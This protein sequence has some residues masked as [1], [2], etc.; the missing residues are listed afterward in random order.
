MGGMPVAVSLPLPAA[1]RGARGRPASSGRAAYSGPAVCSRG[2]KRG[3]G[4]ARARGAAAAAASGGGEEAGAVVGGGGLAGLAAALELR[5]RGVPCT[6]VEK[7]ERAGGRVQTDEVDGF[8]LDR[9]F[10]I[11][12]TGYPEAQRVLDYDALDLRPFFA[13]ASI[14]LGPGE[15]FP[16]VADPLR[17]PVAAIQSAFGPI[18][19]PLDKVLVGA[20]RFASP[21][22]GDA[23]SLLGSGK[24]EETTAAEALR[25]LGLSES[26]V[27]PFFRPF[28]AGI[29]FNPTLGVSSRLTKFVLKVLA[30]GPQ[31]L[32]AKG[33]GAVSAQLAARAERGGARL[34]LGRGVQ[35]VEWEGAAPRVVLD[36]GAALEAPLGVVLATEGPEAFRLAGDF[37]EGAPSKAEEP[38]G[39]VCVYFRATEPPS[40]DKILFLDGRGEELVN[41][42]CVPS[43]VCPDYAPKGQ[44]LIST[45]IVGS[46][47][48]LDGLCADDAE[49]AAEVK[50]CLGGWFGEAAVAPW[51]LLK[52]Y[53]IPYG[54]PNQNPPTDFDR[55]VRLRS[56]DRCLYVCGDHR[57]S[58][59]LDGALLSG[60]RAAEALCADSGMAGAGGS[61]P[62]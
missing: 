41:N 30:D 1:G 20:L 54:Q 50:R 21:F 2:G 18:G 36:D 31:C 29:F 7:Q 39:T 59:T 23:Y 32:P 4:G 10:Q 16:R 25:G 5:R 40:R 60:R 48:Y 26:I 17:H 51:E 11:F 56:A 28:L 33:M 43:N 12:L 8:L 52:V 46:K 24:E 61:A 62:L 13:G 45:S 57:T 3:A 55:S 27:R 35:A 42:C 44:A 19:S 38:V 47:S 22:L 49:L 34:L 6:V 58:G 53:R 14:H 37:M 15:G 9:G